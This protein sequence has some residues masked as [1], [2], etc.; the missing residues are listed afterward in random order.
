MALHV[1]AG[2]VYNAENKVLIAHRLESFD[3]GGLWE[4]P[5]GKL[6]KGESAESAL[7]REFKEEIGIVIQKARPLIRIT[8]AYPHKTI[9]LD[10][11]QVE[12]WQGL[13]Q[14]REGQAI[15]W[16][17]VDKL[18]DKP[19]PAAN[20]AIIKA[21][22]LPDLY[23][24]TPEPVKWND[25]SL[26]YRL[27]ACLDKEISLIQLRAKH[28]SER[29]YCCCAEKML[30][31]C[32][33]YKANLLVN[34]TPQIA[35]SVGAQGVHLNSARLTACAARPLPKHLIV[36]SSCHNAQDIQQ[37]HVIQTDFIVL[38]PVKKTDSHPDAKLLGWLNFF[39][40]TELATC[41]VFALGG[42]STKDKTMA[43]AHG[44]QG[45]AGIRNIA[46]LV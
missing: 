11:W 14:G 23:W 33:N 9:L 41:P 26:F 5:G 31:L 28:L 45:I 39:Q 18:D 22:R 2:V 13:A 38:S 29:D 16:C 35:L 40:L 36:G 3:Q 37:A 34:S 24:I 42:M 19:F 10:V 21:I 43:W 27:E 15:E 20:Y 6:E 25:K 46:N 4:F 12:K 30:K 1:V 44:A 8:H 32:Q 7:V 17:S